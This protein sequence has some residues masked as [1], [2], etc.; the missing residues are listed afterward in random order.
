MTTFKAINTPQGGGPPQ[1]AQTQPIR[2]NKASTIGQVATV[3]LSIFDAATT[4]SANAVKAEAKTAQ[5]T[6]LGG[7]QQSLLNIRQASETD[8]SID[9]TREHRKLLSKF[10]AD[11]PSLRVEAGKLFKA[12]TGESPSGI[13]ADEQAAQKLSNDALSAGFGRAGASDEYNANQLELYLQ[14]KQADKLNSSRISDLVRLEKEGKVAKDIVRHEILTSFKD[15]SALG[16]KKTKLDMQDVVEGVGNGTLSKEEGQLMIDRARIN[17]SLVLSSL[18]EFSSAPEVLSY[19]TP[20]TMEQ[21]LAE[22][23]INGTKEVSALNATKAVNLARGEAIFFSD[24]DNINRVVVSSAFNHTVGLSVTQ[25]RAAMEFITN[26]LTEEG[27]LPG[28]AKPIDAR[29]LKTDQDKKWSMEVL[30]NMFGGED[31]DAHKEGANTMAGIAEHLARNGMD[32]DSDERK[33]VVSLLN[34][35]KAMSMLSPEQKDTVMIAFDMYIADDVAVASR[36]LITN[37]AQVSIQM[38][39]AGFGGG[40]VPSLVDLASVADITVR[41]GRIYWTAKQGSAGNLRLQQQIRRINKDIDESITQPA[42]V[43]S[44]AGGKSFEDA[45]KFLTNQEERAEVQEVKK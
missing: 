18:G 41:E 34:T 10:G 39:G 14:T 36:N 45:Y 9:V 37:P 26:G 15:M 42:N 6:A 21:D 19:M 11:N 3:G 28:S 38:P 30:T 1:F 13:S 16:Y 20:I 43:F 23:T 17:N 12:E 25:T 4:A 7:L 8:D 5:D 44:N 27:M 31:T 35:P 33:W 22:A 24:P 29:N 2:S 32:Y 40:S